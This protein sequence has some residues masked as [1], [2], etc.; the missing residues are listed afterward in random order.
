VVDLFRHEGASNVSWAWIANN[1]TRGEDIAPF[2]PGVDY[3]DYTGFDAYNWASSRNATWITFTE[4]LTGT[5]AATWLGNTYGTLEKL[6]PSTPMIVG[7]FGCHTT[8]GNKAAWIKDALTVIPRDFPLIAAISYY[9][10]SDGGP[11]SPTWALQPSDGSLQAWVDGL[12]RGP[13]VVGSQFTMPPDLQPLDPFTRFT[14]AGDPL[15]QLQVA[16]ARIQSLLAEIAN[17]DA[18]LNDAHAALDAATK[19]LEQARS[20]ARAAQITV[21]QAKQAAA[22]LVKLGSAA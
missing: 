21:D 12:L 11:T 7:E 1:L 10:I 2:F 20:D 13:Y 4:M 14:Q 16:N 5:G 6:A 8:P 3:V 9:P 15:E 17:Y 19:D 22:M 18:D